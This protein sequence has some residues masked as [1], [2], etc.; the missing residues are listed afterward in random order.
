MLHLLFYSH[1]FGSLLTPIA[2]ILPLFNTGSVNLNASN[3]VTL[4]RKIKY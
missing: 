1:Y 2:Y 3:A 4:K